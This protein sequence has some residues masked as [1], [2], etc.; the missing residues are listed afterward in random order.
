MKELFYYFGGI[1]CLV[2]GIVLL[3][4]GSIPWGIIVGALLVT[5]AWVLAVEAGES[6][7]KRVGR[8][9]EREKREKEEKQD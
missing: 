8:L 1:I 6:T 3:G 4:I 5:L 2:T 9:E 7:G